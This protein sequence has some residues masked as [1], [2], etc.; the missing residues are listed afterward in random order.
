MYL[1]AEI[2]PGRC[3]HCVFNNP[4]DGALGSCRLPE[5][6]CEL[7]PFTMY[8]YKQR[9]DIIFNPVHDEPVPA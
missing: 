1:I 5:N 4:N 2:V 8:Q 9:G 7:A 3:K 6:R